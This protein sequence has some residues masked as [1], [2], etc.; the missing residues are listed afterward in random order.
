M[1]K[2]NYLDIY[3]T[4]G[5]ANKL[6]AENLEEESALKQLMTEIKLYFKKVADESL[7][8]YHD[9]TPGQIDS[10][11]TFKFFRSQERIRNTRLIIQ[12]LMAYLS[13]VPLKKEIEEKVLNPFEQIKSFIFYTIHLIKENDVNNAILREHER[14]GLLNETNI[15][16]YRG[17]I[18]KNYEQVLAVAQGAETAVIEDYCRLFEALQRFSL[19]WFSVRSEDINRV[20]KSDIYIYQLSRVLMKRNGCPGI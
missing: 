17:Q 4:S 16:Y 15:W 19:F 8:Y 13:K 9:R 3:P 5:I 1:V 14:L 2:Q 11:D 12:Y 20:R 18:K 7:K 10:T 6:N